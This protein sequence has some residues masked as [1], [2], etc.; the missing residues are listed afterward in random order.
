MNANKVW[1]LVER[2]RFTKERKKVNIIDARWVFKRKKEQNGSTKCKARLV[3]RGFKDRNVYDLKETYAPVSR[4]P[5]ERSALAI[6]NKYN[7]DAYQLDVKTAFLNGIL[8]EEIYME[9][10]EGLEC[11]ENVRNTKVCKLE[12][13]L[14][15]LKISPKIWNK[16]FTEGAKKLGLENDVH[17]PCLFTWRKEGKFI[18]LILYV[19][20]ILIAGNDSKK[21]EE[22]KRELKTIFKMTEL[23]EPSSFLRVNIK[24]N[25]ET[26]ETILSQENYIEQILEKLNM[27]ECKPQNSPMVTTQV[28]ER[29]NKN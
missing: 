19:D 4:L 11:S 18:F 8:E 27:T 5:L 12:K 2:P 21:L 20:D 28:S 22:I 24:R 9:I 25:R 14:Y 29:E 10:P 16:R 23:G 17:E 7:L 6:I 13:A 15:G 26:G 3:I 1:M